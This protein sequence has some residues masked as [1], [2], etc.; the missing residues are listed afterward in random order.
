MIE[1]EFYVLENNINLREHAF[2]SAN[3]HMSRHMTKPTKWYVRP[4]KTQISLGIRL[5]ISLYIS[6]MRVEEYF[7]LWK[8]ICSSPIRAIELMLV[9][10][11]ASKIIL[12]KQKGKQKSP[13][14]AT[15]KSRSQSPT[16]GASEKV[17]QINVWIA[18][19]HMHDKH[20]DQLSLPQTRWSK[21]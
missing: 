6:V 1:Q 11:T 5:I 16:Q 21:C 20:K 7:S 15:S 10:S 8:Q 14:R 12:Y 19:K 2:E 4:V 9:T 13:G 3:I 18:N 17:T